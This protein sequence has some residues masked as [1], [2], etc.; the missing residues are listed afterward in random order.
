M[1]DNS[2]EHLVVICNTDDGWMGSPPMEEA[3]GLERMEE[4][5][6]RRVMKFVSPPVTSTSM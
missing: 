5:V 1:V 6:Y 2:V 3:L 4:A